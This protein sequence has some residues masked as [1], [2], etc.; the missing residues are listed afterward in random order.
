VSFVLSERE[1]NKETPDIYD[2]SLK[3]TTY[4]VYRYMYRAGKAVRVNDVQRDLH[5]SS[6]SVAQYHIKKLLNLGLIREDLEGYVIDKV[7]FEN[8]IRFGRLS[9]PLQTAYATFFAASLVILLTILRP[10]GVTSTYF[11][12][13]I[14]I[15]VALL[16]SVYETL[17]TIRRFG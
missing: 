17:K 15:T 10:T 1:P 6:P 12:A 16:I 7:V 14:A 2:A 13:L 4:R 3:G 11:F 8:V 5:L 9:I